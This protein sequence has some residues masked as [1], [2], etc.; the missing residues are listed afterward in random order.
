MVGS[1]PG[2]GMHLGKY[3][4]HSF[5]SNGYELCF[6]EQVLNSTSRQQLVTTYKMGISCLA[7]VVHKYES[8]VS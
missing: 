8:C 4:W 2:P 7:I 6:I 1:A 5:D 3:Y